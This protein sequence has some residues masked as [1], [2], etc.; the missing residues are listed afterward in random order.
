V[1]NGDTD[2]VFHLQLHP[3]RPDCIFALLPSPDL[4]QLAFSIQPRDLKDSPIKPEI[5]RNLL[6]PSFDAAKPATLGLQSAIKLRLWSGFGTSY[7][8]PTFLGA[9]CSLLFDNNRF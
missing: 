4:G 5:S 1:A 8:I 2:R 9:S 7:G 6:C 3:N